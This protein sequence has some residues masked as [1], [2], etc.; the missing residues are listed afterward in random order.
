[1]KMFTRVALI[2][3]SLLIGFNYFLENQFYL[4]VLF[5]IFGSVEIVRIYFEKRREKTSLSKKEN[6]VLSMIIKPL[7]FAI[8]LFILVKMFL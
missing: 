8:P 1:M 2:F 4:G 7:Y 6:F 5:L 3:F